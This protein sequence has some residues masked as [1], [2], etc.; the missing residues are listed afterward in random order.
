VTGNERAAPAVKLISGLLYPSRAPELIGWSRERL[1][2]I[3]GRVERASESFPFSF[4]SYYDDIAPDLSRIFFSFEGLRDADGL[5]G[6]KKT[7]VGIEAESANSGA[8]R[9]NIDPGYIDG[10][11][12]V[13]ASTKDNAHRVY[14][15]DG[16]FAEVTLCRRKSGWESFSFTF[17]DFKSG[18]Y[19]AFLD[20]VRLDWRRDVRASGAVN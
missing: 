13:L 15:A 18:L 6:W 20:K 12:V 3:L 5:V 10:A 9:V 14:V 16:I 11:R 17:P 1:A 19:D 4:T 7:A 8:R 2:A